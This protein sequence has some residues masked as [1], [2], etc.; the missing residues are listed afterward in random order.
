MIRA[1]TMQ[2]NSFTE[3]NKTFNGIWVQMNDKYAESIDKTKCKHA[4]FLV[5]SLCQYSSRDSFAN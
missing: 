2:M 1:I 5:Y 4:H 3:I